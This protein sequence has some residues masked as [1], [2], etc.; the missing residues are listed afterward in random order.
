MLLDITGKT[1]SVFIHGSSFYFDY[2]SFSLS[3]DFCGNWHESVVVFV[4]ASIPWL[5]SA[6]KSCLIFCEGSAPKSISPFYL[7]M[8]LW[9]CY[10]YFPSNFS[11]F[12]MSLSCPSLSLCKDYFSIHVSIHCLE[13]WFTKSYFQTSSTTNRSVDFLIFKYVAFDCGLSVYRA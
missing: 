1:R 11:G 12:G 6:Q 13:V 4:M 10:V 3:L 5:F 8:K 7:D 9:M 2:V